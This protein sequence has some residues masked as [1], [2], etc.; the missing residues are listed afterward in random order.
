MV[1]SPE[2][3]EKRT[4][5][6]GEDEFFQ[7]DIGEEDDEFERWETSGQEDAD[8]SDQDLEVLIE[9]VE[10]GRPWVR[11]KYSHD[12]VKRLFS[13]WEESMR[14]RAVDEGVDISRAD[15][16]RFFRPSYLR[17]LSSPNRGHVVTQKIDEVIGRVQKDRILDRIVLGRTGGDDAW[18]VCGAERIRRRVEIWEKEIRRAVPNAPEDLIFRYFRKRYLQ[19][20]ESRFLDREI[21]K[22]IYNV[23]EEVY[24]EEVLRK[25]SI[26]EEHPQ[27]KAWMKLP[28]WRF[29]RKAMPLLRAIE[30]FHN[31][32]I[33]FPHGNSNV[34]AQTIERCLR[35]K[36][37][38]RKAK[39]EEVEMLYRLVLTFDG[40]TY[41]QLLQIARPS[42]AKSRWTKIDIR[43]KLHTLVQAGLLEE[44]VIKGDP[45]FYSTSTELEREMILEMWLKKLRSD[46]AIG[47][48]EALSYLPKDA[49]EQDIRDLKERHIPE[50]TKR[51]LSEREQLLRGLMI[52]S[53]DPLYK[54]LIK[55][56]AGDLARRKGRLEGVI[57]TF[58]KEGFDIPQDF[59][60]VRRLMRFLNEDESRLISLIVHLGITSY[61]QLARIYRS[62][63]NGRIGFN[64]RDSID[65]L[66][67]YGLI[68]ETQS[69]LV[70]ARR[71]DPLLS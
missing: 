6:K 5:R 15:I 51:I 13:L 42:N 58:Q 19:V 57:A 59:M 50:A 28:P 20:P 34:K 71:P 70:C 27:Y 14:S 43:P 49:T 33:K 48:G 60:N 23:K 44:S 37:G 53:N 24:K 65:R 2:K 35:G 67:H 55:Q 38:S 22:G 32:K 25:F 40:M 46:I 52:D 61:P 18:T 30:A 64:L 26:G 45:Y 29:R 36:G 62:M 39:D 3:V 21:P 9:K 63:N 56:K 1:F 7:K 12:N 54:E 8:F 11:Q 10:K 66:Y 4:S 47:T 68:E 16:F 69:G 31:M 17:I 41:R